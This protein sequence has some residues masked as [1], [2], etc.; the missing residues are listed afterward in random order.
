VPPD[1][2][3]KAAVLGLVEGATE[4]VPVSSTGHLILVSNWLHLVDE[5]AKTFDIFIQLGAILAVVWLY[6]R[7]LTQAVI[8]AGRDNESRQFLLNM[9]IAFLPAATIGF[10]AHDWIKARLFNPTVV[11]AALIAGGVLILL[12][13]RWSP[14][15]TIDEV[16]RVPPRTAFGIGLAQVLSLV[17]GTSRSGATIMGGYA[18]GLTRVAAT[19]FSFFLAI[20]VMLAAT[21]YDLLKSWSTLTAA[22]IPMFLVGFGVSFLSALVVVKAL[23][24]Y[25]SGHSFRVFAWYRIV[26]GALLL[27]M[28]I[29]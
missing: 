12:I 6:R 23:L 15:G 24:R 25:V 18:L 27:L 19:E 22:D 10:L 20:P 2:L 4:F 8:S 5:R 13:E 11:I 16:N 29:T 7:R 14:R 17:P 3:W 28:G 1:L 26:L 21:G 9:L